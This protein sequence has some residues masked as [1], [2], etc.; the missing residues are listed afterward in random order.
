MSLRNIASPARVPAWC[1]RILWWTRDTD[2]ILKIERYESI[3]EISISDHKPV[4]AYFSIRIR[5]IDQAKADQLYEEAI[6]EADRRANELLPQVSLS[7]TEDVQQW[8]KVSLLCL[9]GLQFNPLLE[10]NGTSIAS[11]KYQLE[12]GCAINAII[13]SKARNTDLITVDDR[14]PLRMSHVA[15]GLLQ[16]DFGEVRFLEPC[17][18]LITVSNTGKSTVRFKFIVRP[19][20]GICA[21]WLQITPP[22]C[23]VP[24]GQSTQISLTV[25]I[26]KNIAWELNETKLQDI[27]IMNLENGRDY[28]VPVTAQYYPRC[29]GVT[30]DRLL[31]RNVEVEKNL[32]EFDNEEERTK[33]SEE[34]C[35]LNIP[36]EVY[37]LICALQLYNTHRLDLNG[38]IDN[39][40]FI[41]VRN[42]LENNFPK[43][44][45][46]L[47]V[48][49]SALYSSLMM[50]FDTLKEPLIP[51]DKQGIVLMAYN[52][53]VA[54][55]RIVVSLPPAN[56]ALLEY[57]INYLRELF[58]HLPTISDQLIAWSDVI[59]RRNAFL[60]DVPHSERHVV[61]LRSLCA[62]RKDVCKCIF[63]KYD[64]P[65]IRF[66]RYDVG[67][68][69][70]RNVAMHHHDDILL[71][72]QRQP[73]FFG[74]LSLNYPA[75][76]TIFTIVHS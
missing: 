25:M 58:T 65:S 30:L 72:E 45:T 52:D 64:L 2:T 10:Q 48:P 1:D 17:T 53:P 24:V 16:V 27:L 46:Q 60:A 73:L 70:N 44:L 62:Y 50:L 75:V 31:K 66:K 56:S 15:S 69:P 49:V 19:E 71:I 21:K 13:F 47:Q 34:S 22:H 36:R 51:F 59:F 37:R 18:Q 43:D 12:I 68:L 74:L 9:M 26:D 41:I 5:S 57:L 55:W 61:A 8:S 32:I 20:H 7:I 28:F 63:K 39:S 38:I 67:L 33:E 23:V 14:R 11:R 54:L 6:R 40:T 35:P 3:E 76:H 4:R 42:A 29:F